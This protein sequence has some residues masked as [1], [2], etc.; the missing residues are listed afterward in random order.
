MIAADH[1]A[2][3][4]HLFDYE[5]HRRTAWVRNWRVDRGSVGRKPTILG[6]SLLTIVI[7]SIY[8]FVSDPRILLVVGFLLT[9]PIYVLV[10]L[11][12]AI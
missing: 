9:I 3:R 10:T 12:F 7:G 11:R 8:P 4:P 5:F 1:H 2:L 6:A